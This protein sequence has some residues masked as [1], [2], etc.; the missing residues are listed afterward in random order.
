MEFL[1]KVGDF[2]QEKWAHGDALSLINLEHRPMPV[3][4]NGEITVDHDGSIHAGNAF[5]VRGRKADELVLGWLDDNQNFDRLWMDAPDND[6][7][8]DATYSPAVTANNLEVG[9]IFHSFIRY[10]QRIDR[11]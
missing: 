8:L 5:L 11:A 4:L 7:L 9:K 2:L 6:L 10:M 3:R 1:T